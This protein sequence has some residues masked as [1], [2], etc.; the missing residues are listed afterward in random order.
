M[1]CLNVP[2]LISLLFRPCLSSGP[3][4]VQGAAAV[5][6]GRE[7]Q[8]HRRLD[9]PARSSSLGAGGGVQP[10]RR[11]HVRHG[12]RQQRGEH[13]ENLQHALGRAA[14]VP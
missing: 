7:Q 1:K 5:R 12:R 14:L 2:Q 8:G 10:A 13:Q 11:Q 3:A 6:R 4:L 9:A